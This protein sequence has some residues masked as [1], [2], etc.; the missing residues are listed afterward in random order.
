MYLL[1]VDPNAPLIPSAVAIWLASIRN[2]VILVRGLAVSTLSV[3][4]IITFR[5]VLVRKVL[6]EI[7][8][9][10]VIRNRKRV[11][12]INNAL[13]IN[14]E[15]T[16][17]IFHRITAPE[18]PQPV[19]LCNPS[20]CGANAQCRD[21]V[22]SCL[23]EYQ[24]DPYQGCRPECTINSECPTQLACIRNK[25]KDPCPGICGQQAVCNVYNHFPTCSCPAGMSGNAFIQCSPAPVIHVNPCNPSPCGPNSKCREYNG[26]A[27]CSCIESFVGAP[28]SCRPECIVSSD[29]PQSE[30]CVNQKCKD[31]CPGTCGINARCQVINHSPI[32]SCVVGHTGDPFTRC[33]PIRKYSHLSELIEMDYFD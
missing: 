10:I 23:P 25:C 16:V 15:C 8:F 9:P 32:C 11:S 1:N 6:P 2:A 17:N 5:H 31:P 12:N 14:F 26:Q 20:P 3:T 24:G 4:F 29:C 30:A 22:C 33:H 13:T 19:D 7:R 18:P 21:G 27:V 28:P